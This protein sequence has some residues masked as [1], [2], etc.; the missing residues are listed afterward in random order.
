[1]VHF[2]A[3]NQYGTQSSKMTNFLKITT[4]HFAKLDARMSKNSEDVM[5]VAASGWQISLFFCRNYPNFY[6]KLNFT[7]P[8][9]ATVDIIMID[10]VLLCGNSD[11]DYLHLQPSGPDSQGVAEDQWT[12]IENNIKD[13][14]WVEAGPCV[15]SGI[16]YHHK[17]FS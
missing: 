10:T 12:W 17:N 9:G 6:Y 7:S 13:S 16:W 11:A 5:N 14:K 4:F 8:D 1:M 3:A 2:S 15:S